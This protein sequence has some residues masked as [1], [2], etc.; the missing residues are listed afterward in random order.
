M[1][2]PTLAG[3]RPLAAALRAAAAGV[4]A[5]AAAVDLLAAHHTWL[6]RPDFTTRFVHRGGGLARVDW[7]GA[8]AALAACELPCSGSEADVLAVAAS[9]GAD[10][11]VVLRDVLGRLDNANITAVAA[12]VTAANGTA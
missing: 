7:H 8:A 4:C 12:A 2:P 5:D 1:T 6:A 10:V 9:L 11:P 3:A